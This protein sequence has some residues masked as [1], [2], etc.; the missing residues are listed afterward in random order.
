MH[1]F[2]EGKIVSIWL[3][4]KIDAEQAEEN[5]VSDDNDPIN[6]IIRGGNRIPNADDAQHQ[7]NERRLMREINPIIA[8]NIE[9]ISQRFGPEIVERARALVENRR[10]QNVNRVLSLVHI[11]E[12]RSHIPDKDLG[13]F[14]ESNAETLKT[15][16]N[17]YGSVAGILFVRFNNSNIKE[18]KV[19]YRKILW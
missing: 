3:N 4:S 1:L 13:T 11:S 5:Y 15:I 7:R 12:L 14:D 8:A 18:L 17:W 9:I 16:I 10:T 6:P 2:L 19:D